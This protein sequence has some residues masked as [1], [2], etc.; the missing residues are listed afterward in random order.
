[1]STS[2]RSAIKLQEPRKCWSW[3][4]FTLGTTRNTWQDGVV[5]H[6]VTLGLERESIYLWI[7]SAKSQTGRQVRTTFGRRGPF[8]ELMILTPKE[9]NPSLNV[10][11]SGESLKDVSDDQMEHTICHLCEHFSSTSTRDCQVA[12]RSGTSIQGIERAEGSSLLE[13]AKRV[14]AMRKKCLTQ[15]PAGECFQIKVLLEDD[16]E[17]TRNFLPKGTY[18]EV[19]D[20]VGQETSQD[21]FTLHQLESGFFS[22]T[23][24]P[25]DNLIQS[26]KLCLITRKKR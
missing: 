10:C 2:R 11:F 15:E 20:W 5:L 21:Y 26:E 6:M 23:K 14:T 25:T 1:M 12:E 19:Y 22:D 13:K 17:I 18:Q 3:P 8:S 7:E 9:N 24:L 16:R 4:Y